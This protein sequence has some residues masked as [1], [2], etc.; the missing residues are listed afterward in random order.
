MQPVK[1]YIRTTDETGKRSYTVANLKKQA[2][3][4][5]YCLRVTVNGKRRWKSVGRSLKGAL[6]SKANV[7]LQILEGKPVTFYGLKPRPIVW[8]GSAPGAVAP[9]KPEKKPTL[10]QMQQKWIAAV[11]ME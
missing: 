4:G 5:V 11:V 9:T 6:I 3:D 2:D 8:E 10:A 7:E 1:L